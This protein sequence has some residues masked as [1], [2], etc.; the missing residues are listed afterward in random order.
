MTT[1]EKGTAKAPVI[2]RRD[3]L[4]LA[5]AVV[6][7]VAM[8]GAEIRQLRVAGVSASVGLLFLAAS[9]AGVL[10]G[11]AGIRSL[12]FPR[13]RPDTSRALPTVASIIGAAAIIAFWFGTSAANGGVRA[14]LIMLGVSGAAAV[15][16]GF[17]GFLFGIP[18]FDYAAR[19]AAA[20][21]SGANTGASPPGGTPANASAS[22][23]TGGGSGTRIAARYKPS[24]NLDEIADWLTKIIVGLGLTQIAH[25]GTA[26]DSIARYVVEGCTA[27]QP[28]SL[29][30]AVIVLS[31]M[32]GLLFGYLWTR[33]HYAQL[34]A[35][36]DV[37]TTQALARMDL[38]AARSFGIGK[39][40]AADATEKPSTD[41]N[42]SPVAADPNKGNFGGKSVVKDRV[43]R[44]TIEPSELGAGLYRVVL[45]VRS[46]NVMNPL[47]GT[48]TFYLH[49]TFAQSVVER[50]VVN[51]VA[52]LTVVAY[53]AFTVGAVAD[54]GTRLEL[55]LAENVDATD[56]FRS[57]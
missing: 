48:V 50:P 35:T 26:L 54:G 32:S 51:G 14:A 1:A 41:A 42:F 9:L 16:G 24:A 19:E 33:L 27:C 4:V 5:I 12:G 28:K 6:A 36:A 23:T 3:A 43:L 39:Q 18:R 47:R 31:G 17:L 37:D 34:A 2:A 44:A 25:A 49:P 45:W 29:V 22:T 8:A 38:D 53:G 21:A 7:S 20:A 46:T 10:I 11:I 13:P 40:P 52:T 15:V 30:A 55:D 56:D 57:R